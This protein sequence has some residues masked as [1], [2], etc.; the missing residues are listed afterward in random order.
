MEEKMTK[1]SK[2]TQRVRIMRHLKAG[3]SLTSI[4]ALNEYGIARLAARISELRKRGEPI[5]KTTRQGVNKYGETY[6]YAEY[7]LA[8]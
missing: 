4:Q 1:A 7:S 6:R 8:E 5:V 2:A 3:K